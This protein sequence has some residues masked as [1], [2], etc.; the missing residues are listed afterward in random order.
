VTVGF[1][2]PLPPARTGVADYAA[3]LLAELRRHGRVEVAP[4]RC[5]VALYHL[6][7]NA[8][9]AGIYRR[10][11]EHPG[12]VVLHDAVLHHFMLGQLDE[13]AYV[14]EFVYN[15]G[16]WHR[17]LAGDLWRGRAASASEARYFDF[18]MLR[19]VTER[20]LAVVVHN[21]EAARIVGQASSAAA[22]VVEIP[23]LFHPPRPLPSESAAARYRQR[24]G[25]DPGAFL[26]GVF[27][28]LRE[29]KRL[30]PVLET[31]AELRRENLR[32]ALLV[33][34]GFVSP[35]LERA[36]A[37]FL[38]S[39]GVVR[40]PYLAER[41]FWLAAPAVDACI[42]LRDPAAGETSGI[43]IRLMGLGKPVLLTDSAAVAGFPEDA[44]VR[45]APGVAERE[46][47]RQSVRL[48]TLTHGAAVAIGQR[49][50]KHI[51][52]RH[53]VELAGTRYWE[54]L[55]EYCT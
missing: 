7:N 40:R 53:R 26:F 13:S 29:S 45:I 46:A 27:G 55:C 10:A 28:H 18:P 14:E 50:A 47:L 8:L 31:F 37:P 9:H 3:A 1:Y 20:A 38:D 15:Y 19:R 4:R 21:P 12:V 33:A 25:V 34:G 24:L 5:G 6:G 49:G 32:V 48:L 43:S 23:H 39:P 30:I 51:H 17:A 41:E 2:S 42:N 22:R 11:L 16:E 54:L 52:E 44:C 35:E 36:A